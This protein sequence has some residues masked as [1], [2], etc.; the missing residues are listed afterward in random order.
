MIAP[1]V[2]ARLPDQAR[3]KLQLLDALATDAY[4]AADAAQGRLNAIARQPNGDD[5]L[6]ARYGAI[7]ETQGRRHQELF[8]LVGA[9]QRWV[10]SLPPEAEIEAVAVDPPPLA[11]GEAPEAAVMKI[12]AELA[13]AVGERFHLM[14]L[15]EPKAVLKARLREQV[16]R[17]RDHARPSLQLE[18]GKA[19]V[20]VFRDPVGDITLHEAWVVGLIAWLDPERMD[21][22]LEAMVDDLPDSEAMDEAE[23]RKALAELDAEI[24]QL[25]RVEESLISD[26][27]ARGTDILRRSSASPECV[28]AVRIPKPVVAARPSRRPRPGGPPADERIAAE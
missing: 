7:V 8:G 14:R 2:L 20:A 18:R 22:A 17:L 15:P 16:K 24:E 28:L 3:S 23:Q 5:S 9:C 4:D 19:E 1:D 25:G 13:E 21:A 6:V 27:F 12:R 11:D 26:A 10:R